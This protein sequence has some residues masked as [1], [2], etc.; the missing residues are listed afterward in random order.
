M[1]FAEGFSN[2][3]ILSKKVDTLYKMAQQQLSKQEHYDFGLRA[4]TS[5]LRSAGGRK[6]ADPTALDEIVLFLAVR[7]NNIPKLTSEDYPLFMAILFDLFPG[8]ETTNIDYTEIT[9][10]IVEE[11]KIANIQPL[12][13]MITKV[14]QLHETKCSRHGVMIVG[15]TGSGKSTVWKILQSSLNR[16]VTG[17]LTT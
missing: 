5:A 6:R 12:N 3:K 11:M 15:E 1:L 10:A 7:D 13:S 14:I 8:V 16:L 2:T 9:N 4:L 17:L